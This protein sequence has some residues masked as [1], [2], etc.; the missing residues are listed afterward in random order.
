MA[1]QVVQVLLT[2]SVL[3]VL[4]SPVRSSLPLVAVALV[5][6]T[7]WLTTELPSHEHVEHWD[8]A[9]GGLDLMLAAAL[10]ATAFSV[11]RRSQFLEACAASTATLLVVDAWF[12]L[13]TSRPGSELLESSLMAVAGEVPLAALCFWI[14][15]DA[16]RVCQQT[17]RY[18]QRRRPGRARVS[19]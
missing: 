5:P 15:F 8:L 16:E 19:A 13:L 17:A 6:W 3:L 9:W 18:W 2:I 11:W 1:G 12:D 10:A 4:P 14:A 7:I